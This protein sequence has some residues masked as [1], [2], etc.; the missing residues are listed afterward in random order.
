MRDAERLIALGLARQR[1]D[2]VVERVPLSA[3]VVEPRAIRLAQVERPVEP[4]QHALVRREPRVVG[5]GGLAWVDALVGVAEQ[6]RR[7]TAT[8]GESRDVVEPVVERR[9]VE[10][11]PMIHLVRAGVQARATR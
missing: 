11:H 4:R 1:G 2:V 8:A 5:P 9:T 10:A 7:V 6:R 3:K